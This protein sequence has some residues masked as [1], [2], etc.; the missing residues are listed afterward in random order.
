MSLVLSVPLIVSRLDSVNIVQSELLY[1]ELCSEN[2]KKE[3]PKKRSHASLSLHFLRALSSETV[4]SFERLISREFISLV[5]RLLLSLYFGYSCVLSATPSSCP[6]L[7]PSVLNTTVKVQDQSQERRE[8]III[9]VMQTAAE[10]D[11]VEIL[12]RT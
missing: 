4:S 5:F 10:G 7:F 6:I 12:Q 1:S 3:S 11:L 8:V 2:C 9:I